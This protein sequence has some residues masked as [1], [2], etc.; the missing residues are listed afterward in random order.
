MCMGI[1]LLAMKGIVLAMVLATAASAFAGA[2]Y[3]YSGFQPSDILIDFAQRPNGT[4]IPGT[5]NLSNFTINYRLG[6]TGDPSPFPG[7]NFH[8]YYNPAYGP[9][10]G[11]VGIINSSYGAPTATNTVH[12]LVNAG[13]SGT[14]Y[15]MDGR[16]NMEILLGSPLPRVGVEVYQ[17][18]GA[19]KYVDFMRGGAILG[20]VTLPET[21]SATFGLAGYADAGGIDQV[22]VR[23]FGQGTVL[24]DNLIVGGIQSAYPGAY[25]SAWTLQNRGLNPRQGTYGPVDPPRDYPGGGGATVSIDAGEIIGDGAQN[26]NLGAI[27]RIYVDAFSAIPPQNDSNTINR[28]FYV[29]A[30]APGT[31]PVNVKIYGRLDGIVHADMLARARANASLQLFD[32]AGTLLGSDSRSYAANPGRFDSDTWNIYENLEINAQ[33]TPGQLYRISSHMDAYAAG[34]ASGGRGFADFRYT[35]EYVISGE[36]ENP[37]YDPN[38]STQETHETVPEPSSLLLAAMGLLC[39]V[40]YRRRRRPAG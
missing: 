32:E 7:V 2:I 24:F 5:Y 14:G 34:G 33:L 17:Q 20:T 15:G 39:L 40:A 21:T 27:H 28:G 6:V 29:D 35:F 12:G 25:P 30:Y 11:P 3:N 19:A 18:P 1:R 31:D 22:R 4:V 16:T 26:T 9:V 36:Q 13:G 8:S 38:Q 23:S 37:F 10:N